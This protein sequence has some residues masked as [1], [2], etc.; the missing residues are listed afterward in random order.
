L[1]FILHTG[2]IDTLSALS[3]IALAISLPLENFSFT[4]VLDRKASCTQ[5]CSVQFAQDRRED[6]RFLCDV[7]TQLAFG[8]KVFPF[9]WQ[10]RAVRIGE[11]KANYHSILLRNVTERSSV[12][13]QACASLTSN[14]F[15]NYFGVKKFGYH[16]FGSQVIGLCVQR[17]NFGA[18]MMMLAQN[19][20]EA[21]RPKDVKKLL[22]DVP[23]I[24]QMNEAFVARR[25]ETKMFEDLY[26]SLP[27][28]VHLLHQSALQAFVWNVLASS[29]RALPEGKDCAVVG[30][31]V[32]LHGK[33][34]D[35]QKGFSPCWEGVPWDVK[36]PVDSWGNSSSIVT[37]EKIV[38]NEEALSVPLTDVVLPIPFSNH[39]SRCPLE[40]EVQRTLGIRVDQDPHFH[41]SMMSEHRRIL[42]R[43]SHVTLFVIPE[44]GDIVTQLKLSTDEQ[45]CVHAKQSMRCTLA[46]M[47]SAMIQQRLPKGCTDIALN[48]SSKYGNSSKYGTRSI[49]IGCV[50]PATTYVSSMLREI[51]HFTRPVAESREPK[52][53]EHNGKEESPKI[54]SN[55]EDTRK[56]FNAF[57]FPSTGNIMELKFH[58]KPLKDAA[59]QG[60]TKRKAYS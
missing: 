58:S 32:L 59:A 11:V 53:Y 36:V 9:V 19:E 18:V 5:I 21:R 27:K 42:V 30:D 17:R 43:P 14:G 28:H 55:P 15:L 26:F 6:A 48:K 22:D 46:T 31:R 29:R 25:C 34:P 23:W 7:N 40:R 12:I 35:L 38:S 10:N 24:R 39:T 56:E 33:G 57:D 2:D 50:L 13:H 60:V 52:S 44:H 41:Q 37:A 20:C 16:T 1:Y 3:K 49:A 45:L 54:T 51:V 8:C 47:G 4:Q